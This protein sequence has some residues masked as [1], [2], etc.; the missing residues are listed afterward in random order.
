VVTGSLEQYSSSARDRGAAIRSSDQG[1]P[2]EEVKTA[3]KFLVK[4]IWGAGA[5]LAPPPVD[6]TNL[7]IDF[8]CRPYGQAH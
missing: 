7:R 4:E 3:C 2:A 5:V 6:L 1:H 8:G